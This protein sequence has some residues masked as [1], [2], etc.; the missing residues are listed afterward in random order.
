[1][2]FVGEFSGDT[3]SAGLDVTTVWDQSR[4]RGDYVVAGADLLRGYDLQTAFLIS[5]FTDAQ[6]G[7]DDV[8]PDGS[9]NR[10]G[11][12]ADPTMGSLLWL[13]ERA[14]LDSD[15][16]KRAQGYAKTALQWFIDD[17]VVAA[18]D[19]STQIRGNP[20]NQLWLFVTAYKS[21]GQQMSGKSSW[22][23]KG[24]ILVPANYQPLAA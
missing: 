8:I 17:G 4:G 5:L 11:W 3:S 13:L 12:W 9:T 16:A 7:P 2:S 23:W 10:R 22:A 21:K 6:C 15:V 19:F 1:M 18:F 20:A 24:P 14:K